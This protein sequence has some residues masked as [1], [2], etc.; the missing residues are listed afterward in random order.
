MELP[1]IDELSVLIVKHNPLAVSSGN[2][3]GRY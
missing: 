1:W 3:P 2:I